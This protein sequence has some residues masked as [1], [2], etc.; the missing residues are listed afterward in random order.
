MYYFIQPL[1]QFQQTLFKQGKAPLHL[2]QVYPIR[3]ETK[4]C[5]PVATDN[6]NK[7]NDAYLLC[8]RYYLSDIH[9]LTLSHNPYSVTWFSMIV[10]GEAHDT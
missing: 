8:D 7:N 2:S 6:S 3:F 9:V 4:D 10:A 1:Q 5:H